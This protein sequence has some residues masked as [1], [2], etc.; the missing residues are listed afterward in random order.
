MGFW[1][2]PQ[3][4]DLPLSAVKDW[5]DLG[6]TITMSPGFDPK[7][8]DK[9]LMYD[10]LDESEKLGLRLILRDERASLAGAMDID[11]YRR[12]YREAL[13]E[14]GR[15]PAVHGFFIGDE[16]GKPEEY[17]RCASVFKIHHEEAPGLLP[18]LN[19]LPYWVGIENDCLGGKSFEDW[20]FD[21]ANRSKCDLFCYDHYAQMD[22]GEEGT[23]RYFLNLWK[24]YHAAK[25]A[26]IP[27]WTTLLSTGH[28]RYRCPTQDD[29]RWQVSTAVASGCRG[30]LWF[31]VYDDGYRNYRNAPINELGRRTVQYE[32]LAC[33][34]RR[35]RDNY[36]ALFMSLDFKDAFHLYKAYGGYPLFQDNATHRVV[37]RVWSAHHVNGMVS[38][39]TDKD[40]REYVVLTNNSKTESDLFA[41]ALE[42]K[43]KTV[44]NL[45]KNGSQVFDF[46]LQHH[47]AYYKTDDIETHAGV[48]LAP[49]Q[50]EVFRLP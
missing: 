37:R 2:Y 15:H 24:Y 1:N 44:Y 45:R 25:K 23:D 31:T 19:F 32:W 40:N 18:L 17:D 33:E 11:A 49:G 43:V 5:A 39:F 38:F 13:E 10:V 28:F 46:A 35:F 27:L 29:M 36:G 8:H 12:T 3:I 48:Y 22:P 4:S 30:I 6:M 21:F 14:F 7:I 16:P 50:M 34:L 47:D 9:K 26:G 41:M 42:P 20:A